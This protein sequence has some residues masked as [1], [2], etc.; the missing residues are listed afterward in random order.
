M[1]TR[2]RMKVYGE[3]YWENKRYY[4]YKC[5]KEKF[6]IKKIGIMLKSYWKTISFAST[7]L[8][9]LLLEYT[10]KEKEPVASINKELNMEVLLLNILGSSM[11]HGDGIKEKI[12]SK[13]F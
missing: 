2:N 4:E 12:L 3:I 11:N 6:S 7:I 1:V 5:N 10:Q 8:I 13:N 9:K